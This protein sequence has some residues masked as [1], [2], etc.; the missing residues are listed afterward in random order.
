MKS[1]I[2]PN[3]RLQQSQMLLV[4]YNSGQRDISLSGHVVDDV[5]RGLDGVQ[6]VKRRLVETEL[7]VFY[8]GQVE[9]V[10][11]Q[12]LVHRLRVDLHFDHLFT[13]L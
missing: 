13:L 8:L 9:Q 12:V 3:H 11:D 10:I 7:T 2:I 4:V 5:E 1:P 6:Q